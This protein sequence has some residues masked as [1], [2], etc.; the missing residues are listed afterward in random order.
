M[1]PR[2]LPLLAILCTGGAGAESLDKPTH[3]NNIQRTGWNPHETIL[4]PT[5]VSSNAFGQLWQTPRFD[6]IGTREP[7]LFATPL[8]VDKV[9]FATGPYQGKTLSVIYALTDLGYVY[10]INAVAA[11]DTPA[12]TILWSK[13]LSETK[14]GGMGALSTPTID[15]KQLRLY[16]ICADGNKPYQVHALDLVS[17]EQKPGWPV[18][19]D[20]TAVNAP[21]INRNGTTLFPSQLLIQRGALTLNPDGTR[22]YVS[23]A[24]GGT[25]PG[26]IVALD[27]N[28]AAVA[29]AFSATPRTEEIQG[30]MW[31][32]G[33]PTVDSDGYV[34]IATGS[35]V[36]AHIKKLGLPGIFVDSEHNW[37]QSVLRLRDDPRKGFELA[38]TYSPF[39]Y[40]QAQV[41]D[42][43]LGASGTTAIDLDP[44]TTSTPKLLVLGGKQGNV[45][46]LDRARM[47]GSLVR[48]PPISEDS[49]T[50]GSLLP[51]EPQPHFGK[52]GPLN[53]FGPYA[54]KNAMN[55]QARSRT[56]PAYFRS[57]AG[58]NYVFVTG[59]A[60][61]GKRLEES[62]PPGLVRLE[63]VT[64][65]GK[66]AYLKIDQ[67]E[68]TQVFHNPGSPVVTSNGGN[69][70]IVWVLDT[71]V[72]R[73]APMQGPGASRPVLHAFDAL[74]FKL[75]WKSAPGELASSGKYNEPTVVRGM[76]IVGTDRIQAFGLHSG[77][78]RSVFPSPFDQITQAA[79]KIT[80]GQERLEVAKTMF[81]QRCV[82][83]HQSGT[84]GI[85]TLDMITKLDVGRI[86]DTLRVGLMKP[87]AA[88]LTDEQVGDVAIYVNSLGQTVKETPSP[89]VRNISVSG[90]ALYVRHCITCHMPD[91]SGV[92]PLQPAL[93]GNKI[94]S[95]EPAA[96]LRAVLHGPAPSHA[97]VRVLSAEE[98]A[99]LLTYVRGEFGSN[100]SAIQEKDITEH[101]RA[102][103]KSR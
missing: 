75:L 48:R 86:G 73:T 25:S 7:R 19:I 33:G 76:A 21:G 20:A 61:T 89:S 49:T 98:A 10:A 29:T 63:I 50:D 26:W 66:P 24:E 38:G 77:S 39:N 68:E 97:F 72:V 94:V 37:G 5:T 15:L 42:I 56:T 17:G 83:C 52:R 22:L 55:D 13:R 45:Y 71:N 92:R 88:G 30:G 100:S 27:T 82:V 81:E 95:G 54:D 35:S 11:G 47:P 32:S 87:Q 16:A 65:P 14:P 1:I 46:L 9:T 91:G 6:S 64:T 51:P 69:G 31:A 62:T 18:A 85:P 28:K 34:H 53:V 4:T 36:Q 60:K 79:P 12:G 80:L 96:L 99:D 59:S 70:A 101:G 90:R 43:D 93:Q 40:A 58:K 102:G 3:H 44:A 74:T 78:T 8:F 23:F 103:L 2:F 57:A 67:L 41:T 84:P